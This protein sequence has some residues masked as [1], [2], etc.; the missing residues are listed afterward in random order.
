M[1][2]DHVGAGVRGV[3]HLE[4]SPAVFNRQFRGNAREGERAAR[5]QQIRIDTQ[6][7]RLPRPVEVEATGFIPFM[8]AHGHKRHAGEGAFIQRIKG[9]AFRAVQVPQHRQRGLA[10]QRES[11]GAGVAARS[12]LPGIE[13]ERADGHHQ[14]AAAGQQA[15][16][17]QAA[18][19]PPGGAPYAQGAD[20]KPGR[21]L[22]TRQLCQP[23]RRQSQTRHQQQ[24][25][26]PKKGPRR[27]G[28]PGG[29]RPTYNGQRAC[30]RGDANPKAPAAPMRAPACRLALCRLGHLRFGPLREQFTRGTPGLL[31]QH[32][33]NGHRTD[34]HA[35]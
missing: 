16:D 3:G 8:N 27:L 21:R 5:G 29:Q 4:Q 17:R 35:G 30:Q 15:R 25:A 18:L 32:Q 24:R 13:F 31:A 6:Q 22:G 23:G 12:I 19:A 1:A 9:A 14:E 33:S 7:T 2:G 20:G 11:A 10:N 26:R 28:F 34:N